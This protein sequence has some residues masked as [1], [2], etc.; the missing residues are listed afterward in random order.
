[1]RR[2]CGRHP[3]A[4]PPPPIREDSAP[5][6]S[7]DDASGLVRRKGGD[8]EHLLHHR[9][10]CRRIVR[11]WILRAPLGP[12]GR[13]VRRIRDDAPTQGARDPA[14][15]LPSNSAARSALNAGVDLVLPSVVC[16]RCRSAGLELVHALVVCR[17]GKG[18]ALAS[19]KAA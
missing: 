1:M 11:P 2:R 14:D 3:G 15:R 9:S 12:H 8:H 17:Q 6:R 4:A 18:E 13:T 5:H 10:R 16:Q 19:R 7:M